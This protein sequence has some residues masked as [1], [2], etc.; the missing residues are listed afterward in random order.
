M[1]QKAQDYSYDDICKQIKMRQYAPIYVLMGE[2]QYYIDKICDL[3]EESVL[4][5]D[6]KMMNFSMFIGKGNDMADIVN[7]AHSYPVM[8]ERRLVIVKEAQHDVASARFEKQMEYYLKRPQPSTVFAI[9][10]NKAIDRRK[11]WI[12][13]AAEIGVVYNSEK[14]RE[15]NLGPVVEKMAREAGFTI[16]E[17]AI[18][19][20][21]DYIGADLKTIE[22][23]FGKLRIL[24]PEGRRITADMIEKSAGISKDYQPYE[25]TSALINRDAARCYFIAS[26]CSASIRMIIPT[27]YNFFSRLI[28]YQYMPAGGDKNAVCSALQISPYAYRDYVKAAS[29]YTKMQSYKAIG[30]LREYARKT[31]GAGNASASELDLL[32]ELI[33]KILH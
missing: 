29:A 14:V 7:I 19:M 4:T 17:Q 12:A 31:N 27:L 15:Y 21:T 5:E 25:L 2:E 26:H 6:E 13:R 18:R 10:C 28:A 24:S 3:L 32:N 30:Y 23:T 33:Y 1:A 8:A 20:I 11:K 9:A 22:S 16:E